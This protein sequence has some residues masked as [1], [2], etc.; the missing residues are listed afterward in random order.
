V[1]FYLFLFFCFV[2]FLGMAGV[3][4]DV[5]LSYQGPLHRAPVRT[6]PSPVSFPFLLPFL[7]SRCFLTH[8]LVSLSIFRWRTRSS[9]PAPKRSAISAP[10][11]SFS[12][13]FFLY[14]P[15]RLPLPYTIRNYNRDSKSLRASSRQNTS[16]PAR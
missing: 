7:P 1:D 12:F 15:N 16:T 13:S 9:S 8:S 14:V 5:D 4:R 11:L 6:G 3:E 10:I 2:F